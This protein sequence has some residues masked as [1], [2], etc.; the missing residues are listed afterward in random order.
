MKDRMTYK[1]ARAQIFA[2]K[3][4]TEVL[5]YIWDML[6][7]HYDLFYA[8]NNQMNNVL[9]YFLRGNHLTGTEASKLSPSEI[10]RYY[11]T[12]M[13]ENTTDSQYSYAATELSLSVII[14]IQSHKKEIKERDGYL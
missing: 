5:D 12:A 9:S 8:D 7:K 4:N 2:H 1:T 10:L 13:F 3:I 6:E 14:D 11:K